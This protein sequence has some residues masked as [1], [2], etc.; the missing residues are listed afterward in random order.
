MHELFLVV[1]RA[2]APVFRH[3]VLNGWRVVAL[4]ADRDE[5]AVRTVSSDDFVP[6]VDSDNSQ[7]D[8]NGGLRFHRQERWEV[9]R[10][11]WLAS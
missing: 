7:N 11:R 1:R 8:D 9:H 5:Y 6:D 4:V 3:R 2:I 10:H